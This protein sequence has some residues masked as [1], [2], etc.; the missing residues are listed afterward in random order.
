MLRLFKRDFIPHEQ[1][2]YRPHI[3]RWGGDFGYFNRGAGF[4]N[5][6]QDQDPAPAADP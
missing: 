5:F 2:D 4:K 1:N 3:L 6:Y